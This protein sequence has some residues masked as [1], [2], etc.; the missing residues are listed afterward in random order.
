MFISNELTE[1][2]KQDFQKYLCKII[3]RM[4]VIQLLGTDSK[5]YY[6]GDPAKV[7]CEDFRIEEYFK[8]EEELE[9]SGRRPLDNEYEMNN[10]V[11]FKDGTVCVKSILDIPSFDLKFEKKENNFDVRLLSA[12]MNYPTVRKYAPN[13]IAECI[14]E[15]IQEYQTNDAFG[16]FLGSYEG[17]NILRKEFEHLRQTQQEE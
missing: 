16:Y 14:N 5:T 4:K 13:I 9:N 10:I 6:K 15:D 12:Y 3:N 2:G 17:L 8:N 11:K 1:Q 7:H